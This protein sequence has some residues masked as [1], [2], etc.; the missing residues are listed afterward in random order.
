M[1]R[2]LIFRQFGY[3][4]LYIGNPNTGLRFNG[5]LFEGARAWYYSVARGTGAVFGLL[6][7]MPNYYVSLGFCTWYFITS[8]VP[9]FGM[10]TFCI[11]SIKASYK[12]KSGSK[13]HMQGTSEYMEAEREAEKKARKETGRTE[14]ASG[15]ESGVGAVEEQP[16][17]KT[18]HAV[19]KCPRASASQG[20][21]NQ[22]KAR[23]GSEAIT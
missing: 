13:S 11:K 15:S 14:A 3:D 22:K 17:R 7:K 23:K 4:Q 19:P 1:P 21:P 6:H 20:T 10:N 9:S 16:T 18:R 2:Y 12:V 5:N 8:R